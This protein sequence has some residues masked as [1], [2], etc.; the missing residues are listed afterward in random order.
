MISIRKKL[1]TSILLVVF[2]VTLLLAIIT[3]YS[4]REE[5]DEFYDQNLKEVAHTIL[6]TGP[7]KR[8]VLADRIEI[9]HKLKGEEEYLTQ[10]WNKNILQYSSHPY[11]QFPLQQQ[12]GRGLVPFENSKW[13]FYRKTE[14]DVTVQLA[15]DLKER[16]SI[17]IEI[18]G[19]LL[20][21]IIIQFPI[22]AGLI[23]MMI[24]YGLR[25]LQDI[26][27]LIR[28]RN[29]TFLKPLSGEGVPVEINVLVQEL[30]NLLLHL[31]HALTSQREFVADAAHEL[32]TPL[33]A[34]RLQLD[35]LKRADNQTETAEAMDTLEK[36]IV[37][38]TRLVHQLLELARQEPENIEIEF[39]NVDLSKI[40][41][42][43]LAQI[44]PMAKAK[45]IS[46]TA[47]ILSQ[48]LVMGNAAKLGIMIENLVTNAVIYTHNGGRVVVTLQS[49]ADKAVLEVADNGIGI[50][51]TD[52]ERIF[53]RFYRVAGT[54]VMG[55]GLGL[56]IVRNIVDLHQ[57]EIKITPGIDGVGTGF[58]ISLK[59]QTASTF[60]P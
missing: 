56:S 57:G 52:K 46:M 43:C 34:I 13:R 16:H 15:Q 25:P 4:V 14:G 22:L 53:D 47:Q 21:P 59:Q 10:I 58:H 8:T 27:N 23:W 38:S 2:G 36:G 24:G 33:T 30:N 39:S 60:F 3:Y 41:H 37:R 29:S 54:N 5:M 26:S 17:V 42:D 11:V 49:H 20:I 7:T 55:S 6:A 45:G 1:L 18:Y 28:N 31:E 44:A 9:D 35:V 40:I 48:P 12:D 32:R 50:A 19:L 51:E